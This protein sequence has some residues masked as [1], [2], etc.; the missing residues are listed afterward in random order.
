MATHN[1]SVVR[2]WASYVLVIE[3]GRVVFFDTPKALLT[4]TAILDETGL[5]K[6]WWRVDPDFPEE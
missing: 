2:Y 5:S 4:N 6:V 3:N 1:L